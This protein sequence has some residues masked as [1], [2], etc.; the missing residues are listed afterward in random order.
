MPIPLAKVIAVVLRNNVV[1]ALT[2]CPFKA[3][4]LVA[5]PAIVV[6]TESTN[7]IYNE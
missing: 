6:I 4:I 5:V 7:Y 3:V 1:P 2:L